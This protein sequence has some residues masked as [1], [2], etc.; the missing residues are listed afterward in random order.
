MVVS[1]L[2]WLGIQD[3]ARKR[4]DPCQEPGPWA[5]SVLHVTPEGGITVSVI[6][7]Q[8]EKT[9]GIVEWIASEISNSD[10]IDFKTLE[11][12]REFLVSV[13]RTYPVLVPYLKGMHLSLDSWRPWRKED[14]WKLTQAEISYAM[15]E[16][17]PGQLPTDQSA[18]PQVRW[19][20]RLQE[21]VKALQALTSTDQPPKRSVRPNQ[22]VSVVYA[23][24]DASGSG[25]GGSSF[26]NDGLWYFSGQWDDSYSSKSLNYKE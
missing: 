17:E 21:D 16:L 26:G 13:G 10:T 15:S 18:P 1:K 19:V 20:P 4:R 23:F 7:E 6:Q 11:R 12:H 5:G 8:W 14:G 25:F 22:G 24:G 2:N 9:K 3:A